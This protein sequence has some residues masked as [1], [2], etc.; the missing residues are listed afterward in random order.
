[1][2]RR[3]LGFL[4]AL[5]FISCCLCPTPTNAQ[6]SQ[7][8][9]ETLMKQA[10]DRQFTLRRVTFVGLTYT[11]DEKMRSQ[12]RDFNEGDI[13]SRAKLIKTL[14]KMNRFR[15]DI[16]PVRLTDLKLELNEDDKT[17]DMTICFRPKRR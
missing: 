11:P 5:V 2:L 6:C 1:M 8:D 9:R 4:V 3:M 13:F 16:Y 17:V 12:M 10:Q 7:P 15:S 14:R